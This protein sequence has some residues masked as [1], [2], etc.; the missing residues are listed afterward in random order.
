M[1]KGRGKGIIEMIVM[2]WRKKLLRLGVSGCK[3]KL[4]Y[5]LF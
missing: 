2:R 5:F 1:G 4:G 3:M